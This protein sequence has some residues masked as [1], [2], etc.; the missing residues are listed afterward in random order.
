VKKLR[1]ILVFVAFFSVFSAPIWASNI[2]R[3]DKAVADTLDRM[4][5]AMTHR[6]VTAL[7]TILHDD[8]TWGHATGAT[9]NKE[10]FIK[11]VGGAE[12]YD[13]FKFSN[14]SIHIYG[15]TAVVRC[16]ADIRNGAPPTKPM[17]EGHFNALIV[18]VKGSQGWQ[19]VGEQRAHIEDLAH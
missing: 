14:F 5:Q 19:I 11:E 15:S 4:G 7:T 2:A 6:D 16:E 17:H 13:I 8:L 1:I 12:I 18:L 3:E 10:Q 9:Q